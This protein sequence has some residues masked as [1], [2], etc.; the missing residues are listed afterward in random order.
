MSVPVVPR[1]ATKCVIVGR[2]CSSSGPGRLVVRP[3]VGLVAVLEQHH[4]VGMVGRDLPG[5]RDRLVGATG[6]RREDDLGTVH[7]EDLR[8][9][10]GDVLRH[11]ADQPV[12]AE[13]RHHGQRDAGVAA[14]RLQDRVAGPKS[15]LGLGGTN[16]VERGAVLD[17]AGRVAVLQ[18]R[19]QPHVGGGRQPGQSDERGAPAGVEQAVEPRHD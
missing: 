15:A 3:G 16:H 6:G 4:P 5:P 17:A 13:L 2:S 18:L 7:P 9:F 8:A 12:A 14:G 1:P 11:H 10:D 19:P